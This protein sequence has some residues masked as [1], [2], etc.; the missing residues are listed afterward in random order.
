MTSLCGGLGAGAEK[1][2]RDGGDDADPDLTRSSRSDPESD[3]LLEVWGR[4]KVAN[5]T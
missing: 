1:Q 2:Q 5:V 3:A 4:R